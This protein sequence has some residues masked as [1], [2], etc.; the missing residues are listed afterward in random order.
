MKSDSVVRRKRRR[1]SLI[2]HLVGFLT[3]CKLRRCL[4]PLLPFIL[5]APCITYD[6]LLLVGRYEDIRV[7]LVQ[8]PRFIILNKT[9]APYPIDIMALAQCAEFIHARTGIESCVIAKSSWL[10][11]I[12]GAMMPHFLRVLTKRG[13]R[14]SDSIS[15]LRNG[16]NVFIF[17]VDPHIAG[18]G[19]TGAF[20]IARENV[21]VSEVWSIQHEYNSVIFDRICIA[22]ST[23]GFQPCD[24]VRELA[25]IYTTH[26]GVTYDVG[27]DLKY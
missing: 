12:Y 22:P 4:A 23:V 9:N 26:T 14:V 24:Y 25:N 15:A 11:R 16:M 13:A 10:E 21:T 27:F 17:V 6:P 7:P 19:G 2:I 3:Y 18:F 8:T 5:Y 20:Q 1:R